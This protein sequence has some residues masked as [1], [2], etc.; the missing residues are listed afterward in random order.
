VVKLLLRKSG[1]KKYNLAEILNHSLYHNLAISFVSACANSLRL[2]GIKM[3]FIFVILA[4]HLITA[5]Q[6][7]Q[8]PNWQNYDNQDLKQNVIHSTEAK[9][10]LGE[11]KAKLDRANIYLLDP[12]QNER[13]KAKPLLQQ[14][15]EIGN[16]DAMYLLAGGQALGFFGEFSLQDYIKYKSKLDETKPD[17]KQDLDAEKLEWQALLNNQFEAMQVAYQRAL[18]LCE[19]P[20]TDMPKSLEKNTAYGVPKYLRYCLEKYSFNTDVQARL[21]SIADFAQFHCN[22]KDPDKMCISEGYRHLATGNFSQD[23]TEDQLFI[24]ASAMRNIYNS[25]KRK[26][27]VYTKNLNSVYLNDTIGTQIN[28]A[29]GL[30]EKKD[31]DGAISILKKSLSNNKLTSYDR[32]YTERFLGNMYAVKSDDVSYPFAIKYLENAL[33][34]QILSP[35]HNFQMYELISNL[36]LS[37]QQ[38]KKYLLRM[39]KLLSQKEPQYQFI[40][41]TTRQKIIALFDEP[42]IAPAPLANN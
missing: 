28:E 12:L 31:V 19:Q 39:T 22:E 21:L 35:E 5:C 25:H 30:Y 1:G 23:M 6:I 13:Q 38:S 15:A 32:A 10:L 33:A 42:V 14:L 8:V 7:I 20:L 11:P 17:F 16:V 3:R 4:V 18:P 24:S 9:V 27:V 37:H 40:P 29:L 36:H 2:K 34:S 41:E 26:F